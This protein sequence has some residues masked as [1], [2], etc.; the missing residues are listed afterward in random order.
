MPNCTPRRRVNDCGRGLAPG[1]LTMK[2][3]T[4]IICTIGPS[5]GEE[6]VLLAMARAGMNVARLNFSHGDY[7]DHE[8]LIHRIRSVEKK[9]GEPIAILQDLQGPKIRVGVVPEAGIALAAGGTAVFDTASASG[10]C[11]PVDYAEL[12]RF[13]KPG[14]R[15]LIADGTIE[16]R[17]R[18]VSGT[19]LTVE[20][21]QGGIVF[22]HKGINVPDTRLTVR[23]MTEKDIVDL[24]F[25]VAHDVDMIAL[26][27]VRDEKDILDAR[28]AIQTAERNLEKKSE[29]PIAIIAKIERREAVQRIE[30]IL[31]TA[32]GIMVARGDL[33]VEIPAEEV[34]IVQKEL[35]GKALAAGKPVIVAT[36]MLDSMQTHAHPT[37]AEVSDVANAVIDHTDA[38]MLSNE[39]ATGAYPVATVETM[40][41]IIE[42]TEQSRFDNLSIAPVTAIHG[43][44]QVSE[45][46]SRLSRFLAEQVDA[47]AVV[48]ASMTGAT[49]RHLSACRLERPVH[50][51]AISLRAARQMN[52][53]WGILP[54]LLPFCDSAEAM[55]TQAFLSLKKEKKIRSGDTVIVV[56]G[57]P[58]GSP[59]ALN[60]LEVRKVE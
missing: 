32:D 35:I 16:T 18:Q 38:V 52:L 54:F 48:S 44:E 17:V 25:G 43:K 11:I 26:S 3:R 31:K 14:D 27:F 34:P 8:R 46:L 56:A 53:S 49:A 37:R 50:V 45:V 21:I 19:R 39:T 51:G 13:V 33:G 41:A 2:K 12:H 9:V 28:A 15:L 36:Q 7:A 22:S 60:I 10:G 55:I 4:K 5:S 47:T 23:A 57:E 20:V 58:S 30:D 24:T 6:D 59:G 42:E 1:P 29:Q 40:S